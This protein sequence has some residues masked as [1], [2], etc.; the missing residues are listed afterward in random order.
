ML[1]SLWF[2]ESE[3]TNH[4]RVLTKLCVEKNKLIEVVMVGY[5]DSSLY[6][7]DMGVGL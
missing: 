5:S 6:M 2:A 7:G 1:A 3:K 4:D